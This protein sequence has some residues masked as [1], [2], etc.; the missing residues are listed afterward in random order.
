MAVFKKGSNDG[1][2][3]RIGNTVTYMRYG[4]LEKRTIG[5]RTDKPTIPVLRSRQVTAC[6][7]YC[8]IET[9]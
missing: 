5:L 7:D 9:C 2:I 4:K 6:L 1:F 8:F 3:G